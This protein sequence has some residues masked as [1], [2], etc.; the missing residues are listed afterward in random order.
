MPDYSGQPGDSIL[1]FIVEAAGGGIAASP[2]PRCPR[3]RD[4][5]GPI[6]EC[7]VHFG[8]PI[9][10][11]SFGTYRFWITQQSITNWAQ[12]EVLSN[13]RIRGPS[14]MEIIE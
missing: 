8:S 2:S 7:L 6:R 3:L 5:S 1:A 12:R 14:F 10:S 4:D 11:G 13:E 9:P